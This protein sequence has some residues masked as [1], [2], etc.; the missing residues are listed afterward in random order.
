MKKSYGM[1]SHCRECERLDNREKYIKQNI[2]WARNNP[3]KVKKI[4]QNYRKNHPEVMVWRIILGNFL[5]RMKLEKTDRTH[6]MLGYSADELRSHIT[7]LLKDGM[8]WNNYGKCHIDHV[9]PL[10]KFD[11]NTPANIANALSNLQPLWMSENC[12]KG[13]K[14]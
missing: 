13:N 4:Y 1:R 7:N 14:Y 11:P 5:T 6:K 12:S 2:E 3:D 8:S 10:T 9:K